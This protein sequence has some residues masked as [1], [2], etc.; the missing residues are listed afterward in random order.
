MMD[1]GLG[2]PVWRYLDIVSVLIYLK[3]YEKQPVQ[4]MI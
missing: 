1:D 2:Q 4:L 3:F